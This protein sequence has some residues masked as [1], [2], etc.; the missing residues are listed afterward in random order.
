MLDTG[1]WSKIPSLAGQFRNALIVKSKNIKDPASQSKI[2]FS[3]PG[4]P[5]SAN[6]GAGFRR[7]GLDWIQG[8]MQL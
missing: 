3:Q 6:A 1:C 5:G 7:N 4:D 2:P 8:F